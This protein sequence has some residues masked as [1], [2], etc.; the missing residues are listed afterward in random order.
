MLRHAG[1]GPVLA[2]TVPVIHILHGGPDRVGGSTGPSVGVTEYAANP[3]RGE[4]C[5]FGDP[6][7]GVA[8][9]ERSRDRGVAYAARQLKLL[10]E[11]G[12]L[13]GVLGDIDEWIGDHTVRVI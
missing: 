3:R 13:C 12:E 8:V 4:P 7:D 1:D 11:L 5:C 10:G 2:A 9:S 6:A